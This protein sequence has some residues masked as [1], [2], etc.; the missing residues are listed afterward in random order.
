MFIGKGEFGMS[1]ID[2]LDK[3]LPYR[4][5]KLPPRAHI[6]DGN[7][8]FDVKG[9]AHLD[10]PYGKDMFINHLHKSGNTSTDMVVNDKI[11]LDNTL[12]DQAMQEAKESFAIMMEIRKTIVENY[13][14]LMQMRSQV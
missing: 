9:V 6:A 5:T 12:R 7:L 11:A 2:R 3:L 4:T 8:Q 14:Q 10:S 1:E 13:N